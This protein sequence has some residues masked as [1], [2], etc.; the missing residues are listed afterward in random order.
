V[1]FNFDGA[2]NVYCLNATDAS[3]ATSFRFTNFPANFS[4]ALAINILVGLSALT[5]SPLSA[6]AIARNH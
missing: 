1:S 4:G 6:H 2:N 5:H 3:T